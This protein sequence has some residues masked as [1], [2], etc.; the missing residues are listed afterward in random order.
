MTGRTML[1]FDYDEVHGQVAT[2]VLGRRDGAAGWRDVAV[3][4]GNRAVMLQVDADTDEI[5]VELAAAPDIKDGWQAVP[6]L[7]QY[8][9]SALGWCWVGRNY[10][11]YL[12]MF[13]LSFSGLE[14][15]LCFTGEAAI[16]SI[17]RILPTS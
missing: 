9:G 3:V 11:G 5:A 4:I 15:Q 16:I 14:P 6:E 2:A 10:L 17:R 12:D 13:T 7:S 8:V 1:Q